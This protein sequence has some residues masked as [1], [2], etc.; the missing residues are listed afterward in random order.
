MVLRLEVWMIVDTGYN[1]ITRLL[2]YSS[3]IL[4]VKLRQINVRVVGSIPTW[5]SGLWHYTE[6]MVQVT[7]LVYNSN[8]ICICIVI[9]KLQIKKKTSFV[10]NKN[11][12]K[13]NNFKAKDDV[14]FIFFWIFW[15]CWIL[16]KR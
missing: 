16:R 8:I 9:N 4:M 1:S 6:H 11:K 15:Y 2:C 14:E 7:Q 3:V 5:D 13:K 12:K 10:K